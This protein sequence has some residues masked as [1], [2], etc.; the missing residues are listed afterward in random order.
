MYKIK[1]LRLKI[2][3]AMRV[4]AITALMMDPVKVRLSLLNIS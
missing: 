4:R 3:S 1:N 2:V